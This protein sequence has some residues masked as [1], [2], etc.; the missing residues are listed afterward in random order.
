MEIVLAEYILADKNFDLK[1]DNI[2]AENYPKTLKNAIKR[3]FGDYLNR[4]DNG[5]TKE[6]QLHVK[7]LLNLIKD[8]PVFSVF[9]EEYNSVKETF[10]N[11]LF[12]IKLLNTT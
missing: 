12:A 8:M 2:F 11:R 3:S 7:A 4:K 10:V 5:K 9:L 1:L 6:K